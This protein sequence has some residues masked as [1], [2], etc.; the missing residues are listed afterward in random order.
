M[1]KNQIFLIMICLSMIN[2]NVFA[3]LKLTNTGRVRI[4]SG[5]LNPTVSLEVQEANSSAEIKAYATC[6]QNARIWVANQLLGFGLGVDISGDGHIYRNINNPYPIFDFLYDS[7]RLNFFSNE[8][9]YFDYSGGQVTFRPSTTGTGFLGTSSYCWNTLYVNNRFKL[10][11]NNKMTENRIDDVLP[12]LLNL[13]I[14]KFS[15]SDSRSTQN[16]NSGQNTTYGFKG[17]QVISAFPELIITDSLNNQKFINYDIFIPL[18]V[19][20][21]KVFDSKIKQ[22]EEELS[23]KKYSQILDISSETRMNPSKCVLFQNNPNPFNE[24]TEIKFKINP[25]AQTAVIYLYNLEGVQI[26]KFEILDRGIGKISINAN[27]L[28]AGMYL[29]S[30]LVDGNEID[31]KRM[32][33]TN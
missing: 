21:I 11:E 22:L 16:T 3:Q 6:Q 12:R 13:E 28:N 9:M 15:E 10:L 24:N 2:L 5:V 14:V 18:L 32:I 19:E 27:T 26:R 29:Y 8:S 20:S 17:D 30:L 7:F 33:L 1:K 31:V 23:E 25:D 4:G